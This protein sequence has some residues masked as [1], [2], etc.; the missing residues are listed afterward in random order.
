MRSILLHCILDVVLSAKKSLDNHIESSG[1]KQVHV[2]AHL[3][4]MSAE[5]TQRP[6]VPE[7]ILFTVFIL[8]ELFI[9]LVDGVVCQMHVF[10]VF[11][12]L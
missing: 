5:S 11:V 10:V 1:P 6:L 8:D 7:V 2:D 9:F 3:L 4:K 12:N